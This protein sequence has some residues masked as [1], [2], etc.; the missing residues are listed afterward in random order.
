MKSVTK[1]QHQHKRN[2]TDSIWQKCKNNEKFLQTCSAVT[3][4]LDKLNENLLSSQ[5]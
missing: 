4:S 2:A 5:S 3:H 1:R